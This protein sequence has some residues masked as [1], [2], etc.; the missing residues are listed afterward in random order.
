M[1]IY[2]EK[3]SDLLSGNE[4]GIS[5]TNNTLVPKNLTDIE[6]LQP[7]DVL[8]AIRK[9]QTQRKIGETRMNAESSRSHTILRILIEVV[10]VMIDDLG[11]SR[12]QVS[13]ALLNFVDLAGSEKVCQ[14]GAVGDR[15]R[16]STYINKS[17]SVLAQVVMQLTSSSANSD[18][19][20]TNSK[21]NV[22]FLHNS[23]QGTAK[24]PQSRY[25]NFR[26]S[27]LT[28]YLKTSL[29]GNAFNTIICNV[30]PASVSVDETL[31]TLR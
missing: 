13:S 26:D 1:E 28:H 19:N 7:T 8:E 23:A 27:K 29:S 24:K 9:V 10:P 20:T 12:I 6:A 14:T 15:L 2:N 11:N 5:E 22:S 31:S 3:I 18:F 17:L 16:E 4:V 25:I 21:P 30:T